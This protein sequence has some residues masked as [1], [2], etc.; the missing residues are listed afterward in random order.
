NGTCRP[1]DNLYTSSMVCIDP[2]TGK[3]RWYYQDAPHDLLELD[4]QATPI[5]DDVASDG[6][7]TALAIGAGKTGHVVGVKRDTGEVVW[8]AEVGM[9]QNDTPRAPLPEDGP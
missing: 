1:G 6:T 2:A 4:F 9:N 8:K 3:V 7:D 5:R